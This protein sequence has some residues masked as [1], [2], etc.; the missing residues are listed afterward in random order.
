MLRAVRILLALVEVQRCNQCH[1]RHAE[2]DPPELVAKGRRQRSARI[3]GG[4]IQGAKTQHGQRR[5]QEQE[6]VIDVLQQPAI[7]HGESIPRSAIRCQRFG[8]I[9]GEVMLTHPA[10]RGSQHRGPP[11]E[12]VAEP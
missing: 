8:S 5:D 1:G 10:V 3:A 9:E 12:W 7:E 2:A 4:G 11:G 6:P